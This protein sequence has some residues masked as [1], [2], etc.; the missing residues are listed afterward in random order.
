MMRGGKDRK[1]TGK[2]LSVFPG[3]NPSTLRKNSRQRRGSPKAAGRARSGQARVVV[4]GL[5]LVKRHLRA[6]KQG[7]KGQIVSKERAV[8]MSSVQ[9]V[10]PRCNKPTRVGR[11]M[12]GDK[13][14]RICKKCGGEL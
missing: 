7:Q 13:R 2:V 11:H 5:N 14:V 3:Q 1:K 4:D 10:C 9:L 8:A 6:R 12:S